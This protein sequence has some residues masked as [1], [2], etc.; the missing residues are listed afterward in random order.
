MT[1][2]TNEIE[3]LPAAPQSQTQKVIRLSALLLPIAVICLAILVRSGTVN[4]FFGAAFY[5]C[6][7]CLRQ[8]VIKHDLPI[9]AVFLLAHLAGAMCRSRP[10]STVMRIFACLVLLIYFV[11][12]VVFDL[13]THRLNLLD[14]ASYGSESRAIALLFSGYIQRAQSWPVAVVLIGMIVSISLAFTAVHAIRPAAAIGAMVG[15]LIAASLYFTPESAA[16]VHAWTY[17]N[18]VEAQKT[19]TAAVPYSEEFVRHLIAGEEKFRSA[20]T[21]CVP[22]KGQRR[23]VIVVV[24]ESLS[25]HH[26][27]HYSGV[28]NWTPKID[29]LAQEGFSVIDFY[30]NGFS[31]SQGLVAV[32]TGHDPLPSAHWGNAA[33]W[34]GVADSLPFRLKSLGY[35]TA[36]L[37]NVDL[38]FLDARK[39]FQS[40]GFDEVEGYNAPAF[41][42]VE[43]F[44]WGAPA[45]DSLYQRVTRWVTGQ[46]DVQ[47]YFIFVNTLSTHPPFINPRTNEKSE[48]AAFRYGDQAFGAFVAQLRKERFFDNGILLLTGDHRTMTP[49]SAAAAL[50][51]GA[52]A[53]ARVPL[54][55]IGA[56]IPAG[57]ASASY[58]QA[59]LPSSIEYLL[60]PTACFANRQRNIFADQKQA[61]EDTRCIVHS[62][63]DEMDLV[64]IFCGNRLGRVR[65]NGDATGTESGYVPQTVLDDINRERIGWFERRGADG[66]V[67]RSLPTTPK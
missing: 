13:F 3:S 43:R 12:L 23:N 49:V 19:N 34:R 52:A 39:F 48:E 29:A 26:S 41:K 22:G 27:Q 62:R 42:D 25:S 40:I 32:L 57:K 15:V 47:P 7:G 20:A 2:M 63:G 35:K 5:D 28:N 21:Q 61:S 30:A 1:T 55:A 16:F 33:S 4:A 45:D 59:D 31:T 66:V 58:Q 38:D 10:L 65:L 9:L 8:L 60:G 46:T 67:V 18:F 6:G 44:Q 37:S 17:R 54:L 53:P 24:M 64:D 14:I 11:D 36:M 56:G 51:F 50:R